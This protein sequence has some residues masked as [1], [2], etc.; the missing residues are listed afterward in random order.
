SVPNALS[1]HR[2]LAVK[3]GLI[4][5]PDALSERNKELGQPIV[6]DPDSLGALLSN[7]GLTNI[8]PT[9]YMFK[10]FTNAQMARIEQI[11]GDAV[12]AGLEKLGRDFPRNAAE[13]C[14][15]ACRP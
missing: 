4:D 9:G 1:F 13:I 3:M 5:S 11:L 8:E 15:T 6:F 10:P 7:A 14:M 12:I 2:L